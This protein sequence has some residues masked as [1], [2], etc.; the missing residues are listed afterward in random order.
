MP[1]P[2]GVHTLVSRA[3]FNAVARWASRHPYAASSAIIAGVT[4]IG[5]AT[6]PYLH[7]PNLDMLYL[8]VVLIS[9]LQ[10]GHRPAVFTA[11]VSTIV[12]DFCFIVPRYRLTI[13]DASY[14]ISLVGF[15]AVALATS[16]LAVRARQL[17]KEQ[18]ARA[19]AESANAAKDEIL[20]KVSH[21]LRAPLTAVL[22]WVQTLGAARGDP[23][24]V[25]R[26]LGRLERSADALAAVV[27]DLLEASRL[28]SGKL[29]VNLEPI[30]LAGVIAA[31]LDVVVIPAQEKQIRLE[32]TIEP[33]GMILG[34]ARRLRQM[35]INLVTNAVKFTPPGGRITVTLERDGEEVLLRVTDTGAGIPRSFL[36]HVFEP[37]A[38]ADDRNPQ[39]GLGLG[40]SIVRH[41]VNV[42]AGTITA[43]SEGE[44]YGATFTV[45]LPVLNEA[46]VPVSSG[47]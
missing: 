44:G 6:D 35:V 37:F 31:A 26:L 12:F 2:R 47:R 14:V 8:L 29:T 16:T 11:I 15:M 9:A 27:D 32:A 42:H 23:E 7:S 17:V 41:L 10:F 28:K 22:G 25:E 46:A 36:P 39:G 33:A 19:R 40:L 4:A 1:L 38:Q 20:S 43:A 3:S 18:E 5:F 24:R 34:D 13:T 30:E 45:R 21:E